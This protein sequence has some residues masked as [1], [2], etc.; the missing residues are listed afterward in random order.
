M[1]PKNILKLLTTAFDQPEY[2]LESVINEDEK[3]FSFQ[4]ETLIKNAIQDS[5]FVETYETLSFENKNTISEP[6]S[7]EDDSDDLK[8]EEKFDFDV[9]IDKEINE[10]YKRKA[11]NCWNSGKKRK[12]KF[13]TVQQRFKQLKSK[14]QLYRW[15]GQIM[16]NGTRL[17]KLKKISE[18]VLTRFREA[19]EKS[20]T[21]HDIDIRRWAL[22][23][24]DNVSLSLNLFTASI[25]WV[26][27]FKRNHGI[28]SR[29]INKFV[30]QKTL[31]DKAKLKEQASKFVQDVKEKILIVG[32]NNVWN[33]DQSGFNLEMHTGR[34]LSFKGE[35][36]VEALTQSVYSMT[37]SYTIQPIISASGVLVSPLLIVMQETDGKFGPRVEKNLF[38]AE[39]VLVYASKSGKLTSALVKT[40]FQEVFFPLSSSKSVLLL[41]SWS[42]QNSKIFESLSPESGKPIQIETIPAGTTGMIQPLDVFFFRPWKN[43]IRYFSD[44]I[45]LYNYDINLHHRNN[46]IKLQS[47]IHNQFS[48]P[49]FKNLIKYSWYK[50][51]Y[52]TEKPPE[53]DNP[54]DY[55]FKKCAAICNLCSMSAVVKCAWCTKSLCMSHFFTDYH[56]CEI[57]QVEHVPKG[58]RQGDSL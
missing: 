27:Q 32:E 51:G 22:Q 7:I 16:S 26:H 17:D 39:N 43:F 14:Q 20:L 41:D 48:S 58:E 24:R 15:E 45:V 13:E 18:Y 49:R 4:I 34:T 54:V 42:G 53:F 3:A 40:W 11:V 56:V 31:T 12:L 1:N 44:T 6:V 55:C 9:T 5:L 19:T 25:T 10:E 52:I 36:K 28:V 50:S 46:I 33:S 57:F 2:D 23:A 47:L 29:K 21:V 38:K 8:I 37:H 30:T 35:L